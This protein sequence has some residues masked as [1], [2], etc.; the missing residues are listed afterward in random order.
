MDSADEPKRETKSTF[1]IAA[2]CISVGIALIV[3]STFLLAFYRRH[4]LLERAK[5]YNPPFHSESGDFVRGQ[6]YDLSSIPRIP[7]GESASTRE[8][9]RP[10]QE[11]QPH[12]WNHYLDEA[13]Y[14][15]RPPP[16]Y[17]P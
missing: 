13:S 11:Q 2:V 17:T 5:K 9:G 12:V 6:L 14:P 7:V 15:T 16:A 3:G 1:I 10:R 4:R 8:G